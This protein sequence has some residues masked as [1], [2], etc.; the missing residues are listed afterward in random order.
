MAR[1]WAKPSGPRVMP[2][3]GKEKYFNN[4]RLHP[5]TETS[6]IFL[7]TCCLNLAVDILEEISHQIHS[8]EDCPAFIIHPASVLHP[9][10]LLRTL[11][12]DVLSYSHLSRELPPS[13][14]V[15]YPSYIPTPEH[16]TVRRLLLSPRLWHTASSACPT[17]WTHHLPMPLPPSDCSNLLPPSAAILSLCQ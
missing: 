1:P 6:R 14:F 9:F 3:K 10:P 7:D 17:L 13:S 5:R 16:D 4:T 11:V 12:L 15:L 2:G 8:L